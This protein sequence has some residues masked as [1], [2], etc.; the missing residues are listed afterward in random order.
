M[1][2]VA[3]RTRAAPLVLMTAPSPDKPHAGSPLILDAQGQPRSRLYGDVYFSVEDGLAEARTVFLQGCGLPD[4]W[5]GRRAFTVGELGFGSGLNVLALLDLWRRTGPP[6]GRLQIFTVEAHPIEAVEAAEILAAWPELADLT[7]LLTARWPGRR[8]GFHR[9]DLPEL[10]ATLDVAVMPADVALS[11]WTGQADAWFLDGFS[12]ALNPDM[13]RDDILAQVA[14]RTAPGGR[15]AT[16][17]VAGGVRRGLQAAGLEVAKRPGHGRKR[18]R[19][20]AWRPD[21]VVTE[22]PAPRVAII[23]AGVAG[24]AMSRALRRLG[25]EV[26]VLDAQGP[27]AGASGNPAALV[28][29]RLDGALGPLAGLFAQALDRAGQL[30][31]QIPGAVLDEGV[32]QLAHQPRDPA[33]FEKI[34]G[35]DLFERDDLHLAEPREASDWAGEPVGEGL[36][37]MR[38]QVVRPAAILE[39]WL[40]PVRRVTCASLQPIDGGWRVMGPEGDTLWT[41]DAVVVCAGQGAARLTPDLPLA[42]VRGQISVVGGLS[43]RAMAWGGYVATAPEGLVFG[44]THD[45][46][47]I[48]DDV[49]SADHQR[50]L[51]VLAQTLP[52][53]AAAAQARPV[54][55]RASVRAVTPD[56]LPVAGPVGPAGLYVLSGLGSRGF[57]LAPLLAEH[58]AAEMTRSASPLPAEMAGLVDPDRFRRRALR[59]GAGRPD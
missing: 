54:S 37:Q 13:W 59:R 28:T 40:G 6:A 17:T 22:P 43:A 56:R 48:L 36:K 9:V 58:V 53:L 5:A 2:A 49:R 21:V 18:E 42:P 32:L 30:Y 57:C 12:P 34:A 4:R 41:G 39:A 55:G 3:S 47:E 29:P 26:E 38:A 35:S 46:D 7:A 23:G 25:A 16:F 15:L 33:R 52:S 45:R 51:Q 27:G 1:R 44:A 10:K 20:E 24:A 31:A 14:A 19:L 8:R 11:A 50:N